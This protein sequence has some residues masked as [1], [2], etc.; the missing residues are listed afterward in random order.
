[1]LIDLKQALKPGDN[2]PMTPTLR[3]T[4]FASSSVFTVTAVVRAGPPDMGHRH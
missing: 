2:V 3:R 1:M 4:D